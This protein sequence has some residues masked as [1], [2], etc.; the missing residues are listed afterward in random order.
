MS[1]RQVGAQNAWMPQAQEWCP[2]VFGFCGSL[3]LADPRHGLED[4][5]ANLTGSWE[6]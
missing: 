6:K 3:H 5:V 2:R 4:G 1:Q